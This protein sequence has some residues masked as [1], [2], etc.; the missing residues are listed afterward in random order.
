M[1]HEERERG[2]RVYKR[3]WR[4]KK[5]GRK[6]KGGYER[7]EKKVRGKGKKGKEKKKKSFPLRESNPGRLGEN[8]KS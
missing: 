8:Q 4:K 2:E 5:G 3:K 7:E 6:G 1:V